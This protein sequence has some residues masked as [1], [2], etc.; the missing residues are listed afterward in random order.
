[1]ITNDAIKSHR[2]YIIQ[3]QLISVPIK[4]H[5]TQFSVTKK[6]FAFFAFF[7]TANEKTLTDK[8]HLDLTQ[9]VWTS[10][11]QPFLSRGTLGELNQ[12]SGGTP[13]R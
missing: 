13:G 2:I 12:Y 4:F 9:K 11:S 1:M 3:N 8:Q 5:L 6:A 7:A 10:V